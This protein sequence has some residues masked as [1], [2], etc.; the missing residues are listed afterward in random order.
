M[1]G[2]TLGYTEPVEAGFEYTVR[3]SDR[4]RR[5]SLRMHRESGLEIV[6]PRGFDHR[7]LPR[8]LDSHSGWIERGWS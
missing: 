2:A 7:H 8:V 6:V 3:E 1:T 5:V 4:A